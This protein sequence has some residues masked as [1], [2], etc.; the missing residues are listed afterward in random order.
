MK[1]I[2]ASFAVFFI[3][4]L[5]VPMHAQEKQ[6]PFFPE[7]EIMS[8]DKN[9][10][11][12][13]SF[14]TEYDN[15]VEARLFLTPE[16]TYALEIFYEQNDSLYKERTLLTLQ[17]KERYLDQLLQQYAAQVSQRT[18]SVAG[19]STSGGEILVL[20]Q[21]GRSTMLVMNTISGLGYY[22][23][24]LP[25]TFQ[26]EDDKAFVGLYMLAA[27]A[28]FYIPY[29][30]TQHKDVTL[31]QASL[32]FYGISRGVMH[33]MFLGELLSK[34][35]VYDDYF[36]SYQSQFWTDLQYDQAQKRYDAARDRR[37]SVLFGMG[38]VGSIAGGITGYNLADRWG[39]DGGSTSIFQ[40]WGDLGTISGLLFSDVFDFYDNREMD[41]VF[42]TAIATSFL[43][44]AGGKFFGDSRNF[45][46]GDAIV[47]RS[48][49][50]LSVLPLV[51]LVDYFDPDDA[52]T[53]AVTGLAGI[54]A[55]GYLGWR[56]TLNRD[57]DT[58]DGVFVALGE[59]A[60]GLLGL[61]LGYLVAPDFESEIL[62]TSATLGALAG[63]GL[64]Y[65]G[66]Q[67][68]A[69]TLNSLADINLRFNP[70]GLL[71]NQMDQPFSPALAGMYNLASL[72]MR[73]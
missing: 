28:S 15:F 2:H 34:D 52:T 44:M 62:L 38:M 17:E 31:A 46:L 30:M 18:G 39:Y 68:N 48:T 71:M 60:G 7:Q 67:K 45:T 13:M 32:N 43:G 26:V 1:S 40:M 51:T 23:Y 10:A 27:G 35:P 11:K 3:S 24:A 20:N 56:A 50:A 5:V 65:S 70:M 55:G 42:G 63:Y 72:N 8:I 6:V 9:Y 22:G 25:L 19:D 16:K 14:F 47:Y 41:A 37:Q 4:L 69:L 53:Y 33:G 54:A 66:L 59:L 73:F 57:F 61:G 49:V 64:M 58:S 12:K 36:P 29:R 21:K